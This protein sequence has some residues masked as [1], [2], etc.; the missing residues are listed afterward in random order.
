MKRI[1]YTLIA[2]ILALS[3]LAIP[4]NATNFTVQTDE[5][6]YTPGDT[7]EIY[8]KTD[9]RIV[10]ITI[11]KDMKQ[12]L[13][14]EVEVDENGNYSFNFSLGD[15][16]GLGNYTV[17]AQIEDNTVET[18]FIVSSNKAIEFSARIYNLAINS[19]NKVEAAFEVISGE[20]IPDASQ[21]QYQRGIEA[22][23]DYFNLTEKGNHI[24]AAN[25]AHRALNH[26]RNA[27][28]NIRVKR[29]YIFHQEGNQTLDRYYLE[30]RINRTLLA[31]ERLEKSVEIL[32]DK[33]L[34][35]TET[36]Q[37]LLNRTKSKLENASSLLGEDIDLAREEFEEA[38]EL[39]DE[40]HGLIKEG[41][42]TVKPKFMERFREQFRNRLELMEE[43]IDRLRIRFGEMKANRAIHALRR[44]GDRL[45]TIKKRLREGNISGAMQDL[46]E[47]SR[48]VDET[49]DELNG[50]SMAATLKNMNRLRAHIQ[51]LNRTKVK[52]EERGLNST[53][54]Q[55]KLQ[56]R[57]GLLNRFMNQLKKGRFEDAKGL[58]K[59]K[60]RL[61]RVPGNNGRGP[62]NNK[63][64][65]THP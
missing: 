30:T 33:G 48:E 8:G 51:A 60:N 29:G 56:E 2:G 13:Y 9:A 40:L 39:I 15:L 57:Q 4:I 5:L 63:G 10:N 28:H 7:V 44:V 50:N 12:I 59:H 52:L 17:I 18:N 14:E 27:L 62:P 41:L 16:P 32:E 58:L 35:N 31:L 34:N 22:L 54:V 20:D 38:E 61:K 37:D 47:S 24:S 42:R 26:F 1:K 36:L 3:L 45:K 64:R 43:A 23:D 19:R 49:L 6:W 25:A 46:Q 55:E 65:G 11:K 53:E 21:E